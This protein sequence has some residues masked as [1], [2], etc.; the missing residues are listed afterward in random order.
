MRKVFLDNLP[1]FNNKIDWKNSVGYIVNFVYDNIEGTLEIIDYYKSNRRRQYYI[2]IKYENTTYNIE[3]Q[4]FKNAKLHALFSYKTYKI[5][6]FKYQINQV[7][8]DNHRNIKIIDQFVD[9]NKKKNKKRY[10]YL[11]LKCGYMN[12]IIEEY[13]ITAGVGCACCAGKIVV[14][15]INDIP[16]T[17]PWMVPYFQGGYEE[18]KIYNH[19]NT[20]RLLFKCPDCNS[21]MKQ[22]TT[23]ANLYTHKGVK[24]PICSDG[25][26]SIAKY[27]YGLLLQLKEQKQIDDFEMEKKFSW[28]VFYNPF[29]KNTSYG[30]YDFVIEH[31][32]L[33]VEIDGGFHRK[34]RKELKMTLD[35]IQY[36]D[37]QKDILAINNGYN[38]L[39]ISDE[40]GFQNN[41]ICSALTN[42][43]DFSK[44]DWDRCLQ[45]SLHTYAKEI[46]D[47][48]C[49]NPEYSISYIVKISH[50]S[51]SAVR[52]WLKI[53]T[54]LGWCYY[55]PKQ[56]L[57]KGMY[58][59]DNNSYKKKA[60]I[61]LD[62]GKIFGSISEC[63]KIT[64][65][66]FGCDISRKCVSLVCNNK[67]IH[68]HGY[69]FKFI[70]DLNKE[71]YEYFKVK[72]KLSAVQ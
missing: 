30:I 10:K 36:R 70:F 34:P 56:E 13:H 43:F 64:S 51:E 3:T 9:F 47:I 20:K 42:I 32:K 63:A 66:D 39:R 53:G 55:D 38:I 71:E 33:I 23:I 40:G 35:E 45:S 27:F 49:K 25:Y 15:G 21:I 11:C 46:C 48:K 52:S 50:F 44:I 37:N 29:V 8:S 62:N 61:C 65:C 60:V 22:E 24:C 12:G 7:I 26:S 69:H 41:I 16:T 59:K 6:P 54:K 57:T 58:K 4:L 72:E 5:I 28:C 68:T 67:R 1:K 31:K 18:A 2:T 14:K 17:D 19:C